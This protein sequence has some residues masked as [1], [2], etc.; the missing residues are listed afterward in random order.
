MLPLRGGGVDLFSCECKLIKYFINIKTILS[1]LCIDAARVDIYYLLKSSKE[2]NE[3][4]NK[5]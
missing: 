3:K 4:G 1:K 2:T 5:K